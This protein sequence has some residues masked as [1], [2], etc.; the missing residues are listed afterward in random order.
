MWGIFTMSLLTFSFSFLVGIWRNFEWSSV[1]CSCSTNAHNISP[2]RASIG[3][4]WISVVEDLSEEEMELL[5]TVPMFIAR[6]MT[7]QR[8]FALMET[9]EYYHWQRLT[10][11]SLRVQPCSLPWGRNAIV[12]RCVFTFDFAAYLRKF[13]FVLGFSYFRGWNRCN[14]SWQGYLILC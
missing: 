4:L 13:F 2:S 11:A 14:V 3:I 10:I 6:N 9:S 1:H 5:T 12:L 8:A 7:R